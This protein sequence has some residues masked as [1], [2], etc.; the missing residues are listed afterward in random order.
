MY[1]FRDGSLTLMYIAYLRVIE[2]VSAWVPTFVFREK[3]NNCFLCVFSVTL[4]YFLPSVLF[5]DFLFLC[6]L[7]NKCWL[8]KT[9]RESHQCLGT[10]TCLE[11]LQ[12][13]V[14]H[15]IGLSACHLWTS[16]L[17][18]QSYSRP[19]Y[20]FRKIVLRARIRMATVCEP[21]GVLVKI[22]G[23]ETTVGID[24]STVCFKWK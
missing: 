18:M 12:T 19:K 15:E 1:L 6:T 8:Q 16:L 5:S 7:I 14:N 17:E 23:S 21:V 13:M 11:S 2:R 10:S 22:L 3:K 4:F 9:L 20:W 24:F